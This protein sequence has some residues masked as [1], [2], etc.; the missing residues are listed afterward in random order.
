M[1]K[2]EDEVR[3]IAERI[4]G[5]DEVEDKVQ[6]GVGQLTTFKQ[7]GFSGKDTDRQPDGWYLPENSNDI[8]IVLDTMAENKKYN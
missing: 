8:A 5:F 2:T 7:L 3:S 4:L 1:G 6:Q